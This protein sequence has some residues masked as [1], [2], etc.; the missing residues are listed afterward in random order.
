LYEGEVSQLT[1]Y[2]HGVTQ[3]G[4]GKTHTMLGSPTDPGLLW[5]TIEEL[6]RQARESPDRRTTFRVECFEIY[7]EEVRDLLAKGGQEVKG[8]LK[9][10]DHPVKGLSVAGGTE[11]QIHQEADV[12]RGLEQGLS[13]RATASTNMNA[14]SSRSHCVVRLNIES[15]QC[16][17]GEAPGVTS[18]LEA[19]GEMQKARAQPCTLSQFNFVDLAG[20]ER[21]SKSGATGGTLKVSERER[22]EAYSDGKSCES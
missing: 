17:E 3:T 6:I 1:D 8:G 14:T 15:R 22:V 2:G 10:V 9:V 21:V 19:F 5:K 4:S 20:S 7:N 11:K 18:L 16:T 13:H 12:R